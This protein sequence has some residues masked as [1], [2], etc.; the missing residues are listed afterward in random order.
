MGSKSVGPMLY[1][2]M[3]CYRSLEVFQIL[4]GKI[5]NPLSTP[6]TRSQMSVLVGLPESS[7][8]QV[9]SFPQLASPPPWLSTLTYNLGD[10]QQAHWWPRF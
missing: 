9:R 7:G 3:A 10:D 4:I 6:P 8:G 2:F 5:L 1:D